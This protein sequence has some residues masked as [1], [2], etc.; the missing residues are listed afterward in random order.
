[1]LDYKTALNSFVEAEQAEIEERA[2][3]IEFD[4]K[5]PRE[6][7]ERASIAMKLRGGA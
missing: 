1:M 3:V 7:A 6:E 4:G 2:A 5:R